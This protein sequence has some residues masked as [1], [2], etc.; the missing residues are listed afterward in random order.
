MVSGL[1][2]GEGLVCDDVRRED[3]G[4][5]LL[6][7]VYSSSIIVGELP[8]ALVLSLVVKLKAQAP[9]EA[10][11]Q[12][13]VMLNGQKIRGAKGRIRILSEG[14]LWLTPSPFLLDKLE[15]E[16][17]LGFDM[18]VED[19]EWKTVCSLPLKLRQPSDATASHQP[20]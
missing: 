19:G 1:E 6:I 4:K 2:V 18:Q 13:R 7:G 16:G 3:N 8:T 10:A 12:F 20:S 14:P 11:I 17:E 9:I 15:S 5:L